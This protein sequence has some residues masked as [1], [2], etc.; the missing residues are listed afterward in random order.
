M[1]DGQM[2]Q[3]RFQ[4]RI[5]QLALP[6]L[7]MGARKDL[8]LHTKMVV[9][10]MK[11]L[12]R[13][14]SGDR[15]ILISAAILHDTGWSKVPLYLQKARDGNNVRTAMLLHLKYSV[16]IVKEILNAVNF[17]EGEIRQVSEIILA[18]KYRKP[19][20][21]NKRLLIDADT[22]SDIFREQFYADAQAYNISPAEFYKIRMKNRFYTDTARR[23]FEK[24]SRN[25]AREIGISH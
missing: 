12:L 25:R 6:Y 16:P 9:K 8:V 11:M 15:N 1:H 21:M 7:K 23:I 24:E 14:E 20:A 2:A 19:R 10:A 4:K 5:W 3:S 22:V 18:H 13:K 17:E